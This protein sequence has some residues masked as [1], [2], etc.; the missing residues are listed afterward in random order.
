[1]S[2]RE[3]KKFIKEHFYLYE[4]DKII[5]ID[6]YKDEKFRYTLFDLVIC[7]RLENGNHFYENYSIDKEEI[8]KVI[9][10]FNTTKRCF[11]NCDCIKCVFGSESENAKCTFIR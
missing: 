1:M 7:S 8:E 4:H 9:K 2:E 3:I 5:T 10:E 6:C 11:I